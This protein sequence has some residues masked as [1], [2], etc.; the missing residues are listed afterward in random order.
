M[1]TDKTEI[2][3]ELRRMIEERLFGSKPWPIDDNHAVHQRLLD[4][5][6]IEMQ[7]DN[8]H[9]TKLG[10]ELDVCA[11]TMF[12]GH[13][14]PAEIPHYLSDSGLITEQEADDIIF[15]RWEGGDEKL[16]DILPPILR[17]V[18]RAQEQLS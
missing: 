4:W 15:N 7:G 6:L 5:G 17:R 16:E 13:H 12:V 14:E 11:W 2:A 3:R 8:I 1:T 18:Y 9:T 10:L